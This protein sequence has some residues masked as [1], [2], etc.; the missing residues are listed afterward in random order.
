MT[1][2]TLIID[3]DPVICLI[4]NRLLRNYVGEGK[5]VTFTSPM[6][7]L[8]F[9]GDN[10]APENHYLI[11]LDINMPVMNGFDFL[12]KISHIF[13]YENLKVVMVSSSVWSDDRE[14]AFSFNHVVDYLEKPI[15]PAELQKIRELSLS[16]IFPADKCALSSDEL[17]DGV[18][19]KRHE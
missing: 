14:M 17:P 18:T 19:A 3:D 10:F 6:D 16:I 7:A 9:L 12:N 5:I 11:F 4:H 8:N 1:L 15:G 13:P 2:T